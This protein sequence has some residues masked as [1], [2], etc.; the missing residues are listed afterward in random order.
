MVTL[1]FDPLLVVKTKHKKIYTTHTQT[2]SRSVKAGRTVRVSF[3]NEL[4]YCPAGG[5]PLPRLVASVS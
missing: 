4:T 1:N 5:G 2:S 3:A